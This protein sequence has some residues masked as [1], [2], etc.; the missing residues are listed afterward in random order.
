MTETPKREYRPIPEQVLE[1]MQRDWPNIVPLNPHNFT[2]ELEY[3]ETS[4]IEVA[5]NELIDYAHDKGYVVRQ[6]RRGD[7][8]HPVEIDDVVVE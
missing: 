4:A 7:E 2:L 1:I 3:S 6:P 5:I 8:D